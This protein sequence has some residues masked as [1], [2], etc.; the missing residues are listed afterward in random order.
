LKELRT[1]RKGITHFTAQH[2]LRRKQAIANTLINKLFLA[3][4]RKRMIERI[5]VI[6]MAVVID[7]V[8]KKNN[9]ILEGRI[10]L[11]ISQRTVG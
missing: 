6:I 11:Y 4:A 8:S 3:L 2:N 5:K 7:M 9:R 10:V 1:R